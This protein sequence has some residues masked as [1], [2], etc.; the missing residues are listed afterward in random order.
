MF[1]KQ[2]SDLMIKPGK[3]EV[4]DSPKNYGLDYEDVTFK[5]DDG[6]T[7]SGWLI[8]GDT[9]KVIVQSHFGVQCSRSGF[10]VKGKNFMEKSLWNKDIPFL[11]QAKYLNEAGYSILMYDMRNHGN[12]ERTDWIT[13]GL[14]ERK[15]I[16]GALNFISNHNDYKNANI[17]LL[18]ICMGQAIS[19]FAY[20]LEPKM[21][22]F[23]IK[24]MISV[25]PLNYS[26]F[27]ANMGLPQFLI[28]SGDKYSKEKRNIDLTGDSF[29]PYVKDVN[30]PTL[31]IQNSNDPMTDLDFVKDY[32]DKLTVEKEIIWLD[33]DKKRAAAYDW[34]G[35]SPEPIVGWFDKY[36]K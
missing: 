3:S 36:L 27:V 6:V 35:K 13:W 26:C 14:N 19:V 8:K 32:Y 11:K 22:Q 31:V 21:K 2:I 12:S 7:L 29:M 17:G 16:V 28:K 10:T 5:A 1:G 4:F 33:L 20:G 25:Q 30:V 24:T 34:I 23:N 9:D 15:D 18:S